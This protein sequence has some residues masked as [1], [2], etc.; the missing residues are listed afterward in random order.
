[1]AET[2]PNSRL[3][4]FSDGVFAIALTLLIIDI[5]IPSAS[6]INSTAGFWLEL[7]HIVPAIAAFVFSFTIIL[8]TWH[9]HHQALK[10]IKKSSSSFVYANGII[11]LAVVFLPFPTALVGEY[12]LS[13]HSAPAVILFNSTIVIM[14]LGWYLM[15]SAVLQNK[16]G[17]NEKAIQEIRKNRRYGF[18]SFMVYSLFAILAFWFPKSITIV[19]VLLWI[20]WLML[21]I[22]MKQVETD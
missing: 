19:T 9:N 21:G 3:E 12:V 7:Y 5:K 15:F 2:N 1:M 4:A 14:S 8:I 20:F 13:D 22:R 11:L 18:I 10:M 16:L 17:K 6:E